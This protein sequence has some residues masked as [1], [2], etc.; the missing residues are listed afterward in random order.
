[1]LHGKNGA[2]KSS[3]K[4]HDLRFEKSESM[5]GT[6][7]DTIQSTVSGT[8]SKTASKSGGFESNK[9]QTK[10]ENNM[11][12]ENRF[13]FLFL[14]SVSISGF[15]K[16]NPGLAGCT[17]PFTRTDLVVKP[18]LKSS[19]VSFLPDH[20]IVSAFRQTEGEERKSGK[21]PVSTGKYVAEVL[22]GGLG[23]YLGSMVIGALVAGVFGPHGGEDPG[24][25]GY[26]FGLPAGT[27]IGSSIGV[28]LVGKSGNVTGSYAITLLGSLLGTG[29]SVLLLP[30]PDYISFWLGLYG[31]SALGGTIFFNATRRYENAPDSG[32][33]MINIRGIRISLAVP[34][35]YFGISCLDPK[36]LIKNV[37]LVR[38][39][40]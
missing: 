13:I 38:L 39:T 17:P 15:T 19:P 3:G 36:T 23:G 20:T 26:L 14:F 10:G 6:V 1:M 12:T 21:P 28:C 16:D 7:Q 25:Y 2:G 24:F 40:F 31:L 4:N 30:D 32:G 9:I 35:M 22:V 29:L 37:D 18:I 27:V 11:K 34:R 8:A 33:A 5:P